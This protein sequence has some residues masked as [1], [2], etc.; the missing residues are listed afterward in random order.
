MANFYL[1]LLTKRVRMG[2]TCSGVCRSVEEEVC[3]RVHPR[4]L[5]EARFP[6]SLRVLRDTC[7]SSIPGL[8]SSPSR[9][10]DSQRSN[11][12]RR[13]QPCRGPW[14]YMSVGTRRGFRSVSP[15]I[16]ISNAMP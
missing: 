4:T 11:D 6:C 12:A 3:N 13:A 1:T 15:R 16:R 9:F 8:C 2:R 7:H 14:F 10:P 5:L